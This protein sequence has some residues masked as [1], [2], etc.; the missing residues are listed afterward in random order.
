MVAY[1]PAEIAASLAKAGMP[2][3]SIPTMVAIALAESGGRSDA[4]ND[5]TIEYSVGPYQINLWAHGDRVTESCARDLDC[6]SRFAASLSQM[7]ANFQP[8][9]VYTNGAYRQYLDQAKGAIGSVV[10]HVGGAVGGA[11]GGIPNPIADAQAAFGEALRGLTG[12]GAKDT[13]KASLIG[14]VM[15]FTGVGLVFA[16][17]LG[18]A[19]KSDTVKAAP[20]VVGAAALGQ[21]GTAA[22]IT[23]KSVAR[24]AR[25][26]GGA[27]RK[28]KRAVG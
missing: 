2:A 5:S 18:L 19:L 12:A 7:G 13:F 16:G 21:V 27:A 10:G 4:T 26:A 1:T 25:K 14:V 3:D 15:M 8:W 6:A 20:A 9:S 23:A 17:A 24:D 22:Q 11:L 28:V